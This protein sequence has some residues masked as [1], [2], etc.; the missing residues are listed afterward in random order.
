MS[1]SLFSPTSMDVSSPVR[2]RMEC[3]EG[4]RLLLGRDQGRGEAREDQQ[5]VDDLVA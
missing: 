1:F 5:A 4:V 2:L 3:P